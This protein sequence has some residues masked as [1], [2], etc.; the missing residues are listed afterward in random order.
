MTLVTVCVAFA[1]G[2]SLAAETNVLSFAYTTDVEEN[3][4]TPDTWGRKLNDGYWTNSVSDGVRYDGDVAVTIDLGRRTRVTRVAVRTFS[5]GGGTPLETQGVTLESSTDN[6]TWIALGALPSV[7]NGLFS[8]GAFYASARYARVTC[9]K[10]GAATG[11]SLAEIVVYG[12]SASA[13]GLLGFTYESSIPPNSAHLDN[14]TNS[15]LKDGKFASAA[16]ESVQYGVST[17]GD[18]TNSGPSNV[19]ATNVVVV[20]TLGSVR[21]LRSAHLYAYNVNGTTY[22]TARVTVSNSLDGVNWTCAGQQD[23]YESLPAACVRFDFILPN[24][25]ARYV[26]FACEKPVSS[27]FLRQLLAE[28]HIVESSPAPVLGAPVPFTYEVNMATTT[29][30]D[31]SQCPK[32][33]DGAWDHVTRNAIRFYGDPKITADL[34]APRY[35]A[36][37]DLLCWSNQ[38]SSKI[39]Y[40]ST[41]RVVVNA[42]LDKVHWTQVANITTWKPSH[43]FNHS[44]TFT[45]LPYARY[46]RFDT[47]RCEDT[48]AI[49]NTAQI[50]GELVIYRPPSEVLGAVPIQTPGAIPFAGFETDPLLPDATLV[51]GGETNGWTFSYTDS[52]NYAGYQIN[53]SELSS[54]NSTKDYV[55]YFAPEG[56]QTAVLMGSGNMEVQIGV[57]TTGTYALQMLVNSTVIG[58]P[59]NGGYDFRVRLD[60][61]DKG[62]VTVLQLTNTTHQVLLRDAAAGAHTL[63]FEGV[64]SKSVTWGALLDDLKLKRYEVDAAQ[65]AEQGRGFVFVA[66]SMTPLALDYV[67]DLVVKELWLDGALMPPA[68]YSALSSPTIFEGPGA[69]R[70]DRG[71]IITV[72]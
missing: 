72:R 5:A 61:A 30:H 65:V 45:N 11:Q 28:I 12:T 10:A 6:A 53:N 15:K 18:L 3:A 41:G 17:T 49:T 40:Y 25:E 20:A 4:L 24:V 43:P 7:S 71:T 54:T 66:D 8:G 32:L 50:L 13:S 67:G 38:F 36:G 63:R 34:G 42:S 62:V 26:A 33:T 58:A 2:L 47:Y 59:E 9:A 27:S 55:R 48:E 51:K 16:N 23:V 70:Y 52:A 56:V 57:P 60:G 19:I 39:G 31:N 22:S 1:A 14:A 21:T 37:T 68:V 44:V 46:L 35:V 69:V 29:S 64:N